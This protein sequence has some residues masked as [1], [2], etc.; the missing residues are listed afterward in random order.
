MAEQSE[1]RAR[2][3]DLVVWGA[4]GFT[5]RLVVAYLA[6]RYPPGGP[7]RWGVAGRDRAKVERSLEDAGLAADAVPVLIADSRDRTAL[8]ALA[9]DSRVVLTT[10]GPYARYGEPLIAACVE[11]GTDYCDL[12]GEVHWMRRMIDRYQAAAVSSGARLVSSCGFDSVPSDLGVHF[13]QQRAKARHGRHCRRIRLFV[14]AMKGGASGGTYASMLNALEEAGRDRAVRRMLGHPYGLNPEGARAGPDGRDRHGVG[15]DED[16]GAWTAP[17]V[18]AM[19]NTRIVRR[20]H[21]LLG[22]PYG[23]D[24][25]YDEAVV[26]GRGAAG[27]TRAAAVAAGIRGFLLAGSVAPGRDLLR[28]LLPAPGEGP[29]RQARENGYFNL[30][31][32]GTLDDGTRL[33]ARVTGDRDPGYGAASRML[34]ESAACLACDGIRV[35]GGFWTPASAL[36]D[37]L[38]DRLVRNA[39]LEFRL[40]ES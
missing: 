15:Y 4:S 2:P 25:S 36:G 26:T 34:A 35:G 22:F 39:G 8:E 27:W 14:R 28:R 1:A 20:S 18:M 40:E 30:V 16:L 19:V 11:R 6:E 13:L 38:L 17:F 32:Y 10:V 37:A 23:R 9:G 7:L 24:F 3:L 33:R 5:G 31:L 29:D 12:A 21:A